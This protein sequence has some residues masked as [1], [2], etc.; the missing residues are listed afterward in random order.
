MSVRKNCSISPTETLVL[1]VCTGHPL[2]GKTAD[3][4]NNDINS[5]NN[6]LEERRGYDMISFVQQNDRRSLYLP[7][8]T[9]LQHLAPCTALHH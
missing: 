9:V 5:V 1:Y 6:V 8:V 2:G 4:K 3:C 7:H